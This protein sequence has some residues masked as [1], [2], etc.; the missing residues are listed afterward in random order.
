MST[1]SEDLA[2][3][4]DSNQK[5]QREAPTFLLPR[6]RFRSKPD[7]MSLGVNSVISKRFASQLALAALAVTTSC[8][9][10][11]LGDPTTNEPAPAF[12]R[13]ISDTAVVGIVAARAMVDPTL[14]V[15]D[16]AGQPL[17][18]V[19]IHF[20]ATAGGLVVPESVISDNS[21]RATVS[22]QFGV[23]AGPQE[24]SATTLGTNTVRFRATTV[25]ALPSLIEPVSGSDQAGVV[26]TALEKELVARVLDTH[27]NGVPGVAVMLSV[28]MGGGQ[29]SF[30]SGET[31][32]LGE[33]R[34]VWT[35]GDSTGSY[36]LRVSSE[37]L[38]A[39]IFYARAVAPVSFVRQRLTANRLHTCAL[40]SMGRAYCWGYNS[41][42]QIGDR[43]N[44]N[45]AAPTAV[46]TSELYRD[47]AAGWSHTCAV[48]TQGDVFCWGGNTDGQS[49]PRRIGTCQ[50]F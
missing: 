11:G 46:A 41:E 15:L 48:S 32:P 24:L 34:T 23:R 30:A 10:D 47:I 36:Q 44:L 28:S 6:T 31:D 14:V 7:S 16:A 40:S 43:T 9:A 12:L 5:S 45:R 35:L 20:V 1:V 2:P 50:R 25:P 38:P 42:G 49:D 26:R 21:G 18:G 39:A 29:P 3:I 13:A 37:S 27:G 4:A 22:W 17:S 19:L 33:V 8:R